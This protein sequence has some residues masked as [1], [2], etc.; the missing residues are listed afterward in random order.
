MDQLSF[1]IYYLV[2]VVNTPA[3][4]FA[5]LMGQLTDSLTTPLAGYACDNLKTKL[6]Q[7]VLWYAVGFL[8][9]IFSFPMIFR[10][11]QASSITKEY[12]YY[13]GFAS[14]FNFGWAF[15]QIS[16]LSLPPALSC[17]RLRRVRITEIVRNASITSAIRSR[18]SQTSL[19]WLFYHCFSRW[20][21]TTPATTSRSRCWWCVW[22]R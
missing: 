6:G 22:V 20:C 13:G 12:L 15:G 9:C 10:N 7:R 4:G 3:A 2:T 21:Q 17:S 19:C 8:I 11:I 18:S 5:F 1:A 14:L 16:H